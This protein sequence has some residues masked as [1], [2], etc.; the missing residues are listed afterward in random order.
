MI[1]KVGLATSLL[2]GLAACTES[3]PNSPSTPAM[4]SFAGTWSGDLNLQT[5]ATRMTWTLT[6]SGTSVSGPVIVTLPSGIVLMNG[7]LN[8]TV[9]GSTLPYTIAVSPGGIPSQ[10]ACGGQLGGTVSEASGTSPVT[11]SGSYSVTSSTCTTPFSSGTFTLS[12]Q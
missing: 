5:T 3:S 2:V 6:Q 8:G 7:T 1:F 10:P 9:S 4:T 12:R 11:L